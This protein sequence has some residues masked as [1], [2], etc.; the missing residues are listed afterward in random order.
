M[1]ELEAIAGVIRTG[2][3][4]LVT[5]HRNPD[6]DAI[7]S[8]LALA[9]SLESI[10]KKGTAL[11]DPMIPKNYFF[12]PGMQSV[13]TKLEPDETFDAAIALECPDDSRIPMSERVM[14]VPL[15]INIDHHQENTAFGH[16]NL[17]VPEASAV[18]E[19][20]FELIRLLGVKLNLEIAVN[21]YMAI[22][23]DTGGFSFSNTRAQTF[24]LASE[25]VRAGVK[26]DEINRKVYGENPPSKYKLLG[27]ALN[28]FSLSDD[29]KIAWISL[30]END[31]SKT[32]TGPE[33]TDG[34]INHLQ[35]VKGVVVA[36]FFREIGKKIKVS[37][38]SRENVD[39]NRIAGVFGGGGHIFAAGCS[40]HGTLEEVR[41]KVI[42]EVKKAVS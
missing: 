9:L 4:F 40:V 39:V 15:I 35:T 41:E 10:G 37:F 32:G 30:K 29:G 34:F 7:G 24:N 23:T 25:L 42:N 5:A 28:T 20:V 13:R 22:L 1:D 19:P 26:P 36:L 12:L 6:G 11:S 8:Q 31:F 21:L 27:R 16:L 14:K 17:V 33:D 18:A 3:K 38:R 2:N